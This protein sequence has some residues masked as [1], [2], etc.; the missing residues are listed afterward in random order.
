M[1][2]NPL[3]AAS[4]RFA[5]WLARII[6]VGVKAVQVSNLASVVMFHQGQPRSHHGPP[7]VNR[8]QAQKP[9]MNKLKVY[10]PIAIVAAVVIALVFRV[11]KLRQIVVGA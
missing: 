5:E 7:S 8:A 3:F 6:V 2:K 11:G 1:T 4:R 9:P 10:L